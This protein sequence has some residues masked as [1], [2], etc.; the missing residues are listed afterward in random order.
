MNIHT[1]KEKV[2]TLAV[3]LIIEKKLFMTATRIFLDAI[4][5]L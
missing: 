5:T 1:N 4:H 3:R 2:N